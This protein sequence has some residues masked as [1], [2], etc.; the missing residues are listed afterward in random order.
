M[1]SEQF[2]ELVKSCLKDTEKTLCNKAKEY[3]SNTDRFHNF[4]L[5]AQ[6]GNTTPE[7]ALWGM[8]IKHLVSVVDLIENSD[9][10]RSSEYI[11][12]KCGDLRNYLILLEGII[13][14]READ[15][16]EYNDSCKTELCWKHEIKD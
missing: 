3:A 7:K 12:E 4:R 11:R 5:A 6:I 13:R 9:T 15:R 14:E 2:N 8:A 1:N 10:P 16:V